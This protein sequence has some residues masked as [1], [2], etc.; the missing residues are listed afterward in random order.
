MQPQK[1]IQKGVE[2]TCCQYGLVKELK[3]QFCIKEWNHNYTKMMDTQFKARL[4][5][6]I[7]YNS[8]LELIFILNLKTLLDM[9]HN[10]FSFIFKVWRYCFECLHIIKMV[11]Q[12]GV[13]TKAIYYF[14]M[15]MPISN[16]EM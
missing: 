2:L 15:K 8:W 9:M 16:E 4:C 13:N 14:K 11:V 6:L 12:I 10:K 3:D 1:Y 7:R 5:Y